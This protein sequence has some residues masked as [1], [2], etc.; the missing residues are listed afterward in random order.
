MF[1]SYD[2]NMGGGSWIWMVVVMVPL[3]AG[4]AV[5]V[6]WLLRRPLQA[7]PTQAR[8]PAHHEAEKVLGE[9]FARGEIDEAEF[10]ARRTALRRQ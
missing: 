10:T 3:W 7:A 6:W 9:R 5:L 8:E 2:G 4:V 1:G